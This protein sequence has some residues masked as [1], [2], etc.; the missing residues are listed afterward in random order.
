[1]IQRRRFAGALL[2]P[3]AAVSFDIRAKGRPDLARQFAE[4]EKKTGGRLGVHVLDTATARRAG[5]RQDERFAMCS[6]FKFLAAALVL[7]RVDQGK[8]R[9]ERRITYARDELVTY[10]PVTEKHAGTDGMSM[11]Q[12]CEAAVT[13]SDNTAANLMLAS[14]GGPAGLTA[15]MRSLGDPHTRLDR[16]EPGLNEARAG[17]PRDTTTPAAMVDSMQ[18]ILL[19]DALSPGSRALLL[20]WLDDNK[21]GGERIRA[22]LPADWKVGDKTGTGENGAA[23]DIAILR[24]P[25]RPPVLLSVYL[26]ETKASMADRNAAHAAVAAAV[27]TW[28]GNGA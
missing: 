28:V 9:L 2:L 22:G 23:N 20:Q 4:I 18:K 13:L 21:T 10:S 27:V 8:E 19:G 25:G 16:I 26:T 24:P 7:A 1:M 11:A 15:F 17:D 14:V 6:T 3:L 12:L 5:H